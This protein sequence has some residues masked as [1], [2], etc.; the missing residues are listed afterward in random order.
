MLYIYH[1]I[2]TFL[3]KLKCSC[4]F[5]GSKC[6]NFPSCV[7]LAGGNITKHQSLFSYPLFMN[8]LI[9]NNQLFFAQN[10]LGNIFYLFGIL[11][12][13]ISGTAYTPHYEGNCWNVLCRTISVFFLKMYKHSISEMHLFCQNCRSIQVTKYT[14]LS[15]LYHPMNK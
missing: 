1:R 13:W 8:A 11:M 14:L 3:I 7:V 12:F 4:C 6:Y 9:Q 10:T 15:V 2:C 5:D